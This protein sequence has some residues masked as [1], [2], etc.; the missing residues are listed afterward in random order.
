MHPSAESQA[1]QDEGAGKNMN[2]IRDNHGAV[3]LVS[4]YLTEEFSHGFDQLGH[5]AFR[6]PVVDEVGI[7]AVGDDPL[8]AEDGEMLG[9]IGVG[10]MHFLVKVAHGHFLVLQQ[11]KDFHANG[12]GHGFEEFGYILDMVVLHGTV[13][14][15]EVKRQ[16]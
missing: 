12:V 14:S 16:L 3:S 10:G 1:D 7:L 11:A 9:H 4:G 2:P 6:D 8:V 15:P 5:A 13:S